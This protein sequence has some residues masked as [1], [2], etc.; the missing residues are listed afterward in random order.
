MKRS[1]LVAVAFAVLA[2]GFSACKAAHH[3]GNDSMRAR[4]GTIATAPTR[5][6]QE[7]ASASVHL[8]RPFALAHES[9]C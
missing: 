6:E 2:C 9:F 4:G 1:I 8:H 5:F 3:A 7:N